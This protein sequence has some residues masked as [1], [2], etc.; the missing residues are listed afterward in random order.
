LFIADQLL[1]LMIVAA[2]RII[3]DVHEK[4]PVFTMK[5]VI[6]VYQKGE[7]AFLYTQCA[8]SVW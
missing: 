5:T 1:P 4:I 2:M 6:C 7:T 3:A 8:G